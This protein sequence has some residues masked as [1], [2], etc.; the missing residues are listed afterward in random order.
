M[1]PLGFGSSKIS[2]NTH[3]QGVNGKSS[4]IKRSK[5]VFISQQSYHKTFH[6]VALV[7]VEKK[8]KKPPVKTA[9]FYGHEMVTISSHRKKTPS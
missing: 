1:S 6:F 2:I 9:G 7:L 5:D 8:S 3:K 4:A